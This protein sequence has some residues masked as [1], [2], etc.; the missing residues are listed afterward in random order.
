MKRSVHRSRGAPTR[1]PESPA[2]RSRPLPR[3]AARQRRAASPGRLRTPGSSASAQPRSLPS[4]ALARPHGSASP[5]HVRRDR[6]GSAWGVARPGG[7]PWVR[8]H[9]RSPR[10]AVPS[11]GYAVVWA[12]DDSTGGDRQSTGKYRYLSPATCDESVWWPQVYG[13]R[14]SQP[15]SRGYSR[16][17]G[18]C[19]P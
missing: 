9:H 16:R 4:K 8:T 10:T 13:H 2:N 3:T 5:G 1:R 7:R 19:V 11:G 17:D 12:R 6:W 14:S 15:S 18:S